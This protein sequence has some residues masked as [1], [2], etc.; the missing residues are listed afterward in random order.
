MAYKLLVADD[1]YWAREKL[2]HILNWSQLDMEFLEP[3]C[4]GQEVL[5]RL[6]SEQPDVL[7]TDINMPGLNG[8]EL[9]EQL[10]AEHSDMVMLVVSGYD[11]FDYVKKSMRSGAINY[12]L[13][14]VSKQDMTA[15]MSEVLELLHQRKSNRQKQ[16]E[17]QAQMERAASLLQDRELS[18]LL[19]TPAGAVEPAAMSAAGEGE[20]YVTLLKVHNL[21]HAIDQFH[22]DINELSYDCFLL[23]TL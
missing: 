16:Q 6:Q 10:A 15:A 23:G 9:L 12:L 18:L 22:N 4:D 7:L 14:P 1:E 21:S 11:T 17:Q 20:Y 5:Q 8:V 2:R 19:E 13:K 3:A